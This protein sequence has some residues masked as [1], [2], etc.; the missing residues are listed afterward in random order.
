MKLKGS[1]HIEF[2]E[3]K[4]LDIAKQIV[5]TAVDNYKHR[6]DVKIPDVREDLIPGFSHEYINYM[7]GGTYRASFK[8]LNEAIMT[9]RIRGVAA[10]GV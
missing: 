6:G 5:K 2:D 10:V 1:V 8:P 9:G 4:A 7:L 3:H